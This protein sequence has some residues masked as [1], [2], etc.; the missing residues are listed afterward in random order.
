MKKLFVLLLSVVLI[1][2][3]NAQVYLG[4]GWSSRDVNYRAGYLL[5]KKIDF[6]A[7]FESPVF[8]QNNRPSIQS[9]TVGYHF[10]LIENEDLETR[11]TFSLH[12][13]AANFHTNMVDK[14]DVKHE[15]NFLMFSGGIQLNALSPVGGFYTYATYC[16]S[17]FIGIGFI[18]FPSGIN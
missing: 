17:P 13:G 10:Q 1:G 11:L 6:L 15:N 4:G 14:E 12:A 7:S 8:N 5:D 16:E 9:A 3:L 2:T 18:F